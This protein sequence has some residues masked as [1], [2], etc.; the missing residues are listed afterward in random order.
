MY[1]LVMLCSLFMVSCVCMCV[2]LNLTTTMTIHKITFAG[3]KERKKPRKKV[4]QLVTCVKK[5][6]RCILYENALLL[7]NYPIPSKME[8]LFQDNGVHK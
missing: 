2:L 6:E 1:W 7:E 5:L 8:R 3:V 4:A